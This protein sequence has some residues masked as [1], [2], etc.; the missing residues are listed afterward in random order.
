MEMEW[1]NTTNQ[2]EGKIDGIECKG[3]GMEKLVKKLFCKMDLEME[4]NGNG[5]ELEIIRS[6][7]WN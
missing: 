5:M 7:V 4:R 2:V 3:N 6:S 1:K